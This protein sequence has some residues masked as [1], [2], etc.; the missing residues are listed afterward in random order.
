[1][2]VPRG[3]MSAERTRPGVAPGAGVPPRS[4][5]L[6][7][8][9]DWVRH[10]RIGELFFTR[11]GN[12]PARSLIVSFG[13]LILFGSLLLSLPAAAAARGVGYIDAL[14]TA[15]SAVC[16]T[17]LTTLETAFTWS[18]FGKVV[19]II[20]VQLGGLG[21]MSLAAFMT[22]AVGRELGLKQD[23][24]LRGA[25]DEPNAGEMKTLVKAI[26]VW[27]LT[28]EA[29]G[30]LLL[31]PRFAMLM[32][33]S[34]ALVYAIFHSI[35]A[36]CNAGFSLYPGGM[37]SFASDPWVSFTL[38]L[39]VT[40]GGFGFGV[41]VAIGRR[42]LARRRTRLALHPRLVLVTSFTLVWA[43]AIA[44][45]VLEYDGVLL[46][47]PLNDKIVASIFHAVSARTAGF[48]TVEL[49]GIAPAT[50]L[51][52]CMLMF[53]GASP[54]SCG[55]GVKVTT[56]ALACLCIRALV[57]GDGEILVFGRTVPAS[58]A[59]R[60]LALMSAAAATLFLGLGALLL[61]ES[62][63]FM[64]LA[65]EATSALGTVGLS[66]GVTG[67]L[68]SAGRLIVCALMFVGRVGPLTVIAAASVTRPRV[69]LGFPE[70]RVLIG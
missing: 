52:L 17:G 70:D 43:G 39:L 29:L 31:F 47:L 51:V 48:N 58:F 8:A 23:A 33:M 61:T 49:S 41:L 42:L 69:R 44:F 24:L 6:A 26:V 19:I 35:S 63:G 38:A 18:P 50:V 28:I 4:N 37:V 20:L 13:A 53:I 54:G 57:R 7:R 14:F 66:M 34:D 46:A 45:F 16:V 59:M 25:Y 62:I 55:G 2:R 36:F 60:A 22:L 68:S 56:F 64:P 65:F 15:V 5:L 27:T 67:E 40:I 12:H 3:E 32:P 11:I 9:R 21:I 10:A 1:M 30:A